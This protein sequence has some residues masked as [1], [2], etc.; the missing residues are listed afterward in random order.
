MFETIKLV[1]T[2]FNEEALI[3]SFASLL[4]VLFIFIT[5]WLYNRKRFHQLSHQIPASVVKSYLDTI[6]Q[7]SNAL[8]SS[9]FRGGGQDLGPGIASVVPVS[10]LPSS[11]TIP[12]E[13]LNQKNAEI[14]LLQSQLTE[15]VNIINDLEKKITGMASSSASDNSAE[16]DKLKKR[17]SELETEVARLEKELANAEKMAASGSGDPALINNLTKERDELKARLQEY[18]IIEDDLANLKR[19]QIENEELKKQLGEK[20]GAAPAA[21]PAEPPPPPPK[22][23]A[24]PEKE[25]APPKKEEPPAAAPPPPPPPK[26]EDSG[27]VPDKL[28][29]EEKSAE[30]LLS[31][32]EKM[33]G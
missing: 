11:N 20:G 25:E 10:N 7:N 9:L 12:T 22:E 26:A 17:I 29:G 19:L 23:E 15:K 31:E 14:S 1:F 16:V 13:L 6:I 30:D 2:Q 3:I 27:G 4:L 8:K 24:L 33:L 32:F 18:E 5:Y 28:A 21:K